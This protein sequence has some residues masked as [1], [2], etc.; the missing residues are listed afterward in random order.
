MARFLCLG[1]GCCRAEW[2]E[3]VYSGAEVYTAHTSH[4]SVGARPSPGSL[5]GDKCQDPEEGQCQDPE[6][7]HC[8]DPKESQSVSGS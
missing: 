2:P 4:R 7:G 1:A 3:Q 8:Q 6:K 5:E